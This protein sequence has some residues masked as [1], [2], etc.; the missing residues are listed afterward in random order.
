MW[1]RPYLDE[2]TKQRASAWGLGAAAKRGWLKTLLVLAQHSPGRVALRSQRKAVGKAFDKMLT[3]LSHLHAIPSSALWTEALEILELFHCTEFYS[4]VALMLEQA[5]KRGYPTLVDQFMGH[6]CV[7]AKSFYVKVAAKLQNVVLLKRLL[8]RGTPIDISSAIEV[9]TRHRFGEHVEVAGYLS[10]GDRVKVVC[11]ATANKKWRKLLLWTLEHTT[12]SDDRCRTTIG[13]AIMQ[14][15][16]DIE[17]WLRENLTEAEIWKWCAPA[18]K[19]RR[20]D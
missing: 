4:Y 3:E 11:D 7:G 17:Q 9:G 16:A 10:E 1:C 13:N 5:L 8:A 19:R 2:N 14:A 20:V 18:H 15:P 12:F 6:G